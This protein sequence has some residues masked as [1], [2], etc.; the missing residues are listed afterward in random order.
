MFRLLIELQITF[1]TTQS[2]LCREQEKENI[3][4]ELNGDGDDDIE[5]IDEKERILRD[6]MRSLPL[7]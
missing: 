2:F 6:Q 3:A 7:F 1:T 4:N 5:Y